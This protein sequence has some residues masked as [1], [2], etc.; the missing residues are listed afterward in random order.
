[1]MNASRRIGSVLLVE[2][3]LDIQDWLATLVRRAIPGAVVSTASSV[4]DAKR[5]ISQELVTLAV[6]DL[7]LP[8][9]S[10][11]DVI[12]DII[13]RDPSILCIA[14]TGHDDDEHVLSALTAGAQG[15]LLKS[16]PAALLIEQ[17]R[18]AVVAGVPP[19]APMIAQRLLQH[20]TRV[21]TEGQDMAA[22]E[23]DLAQLSR[24]ER[25]V[26]SLIAQ[27]LHIAQVARALNISSHTVC[28][29]LKNIYRKRNISG[30]A[31]AALE[32]RRLGLVR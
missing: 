20:F 30:R 8:D 24:R 32:A 12:T 7:G 31:E 21:E 18:L 13:G 25:G 3:K 16:Q 1:M 17:I 10:G 9:G 23:E 5:I 29:H 6:V 15:Y 14:T 28:S 27:G 11:T 22:P 2:D 4:R 19:I 26:L